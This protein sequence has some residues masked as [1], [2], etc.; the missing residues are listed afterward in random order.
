M[1]YVG[2]TAIEILEATPDLCT[3]RI[4]L[5]ELHHQPYGLVHGGVYCTLVETLASTGAAMW[6][7]ANGRAG[8]VGVSNTTDFLRAT[9][10]GVL[11]GTATPVYRGRSQQLWQVVVTREKDGREVARG[12]IRLQNVGSID[13]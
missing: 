7:M 2:Q 3:G 9:K 1:N 4:V 13:F 8:A 11:L 6:A 10:D 5:S 12:Q